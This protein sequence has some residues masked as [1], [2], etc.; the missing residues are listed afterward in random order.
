MV[1]RWG[2]FDLRIF[3]FRAKMRE[4]EVANAKVRI[5]EGEGAKVRGCNGEERRC[6]KESASVRRRRSD[7]TIASSPPQLRIK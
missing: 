2:H 1:F 3:P 6:E 4:S 5:N 7:I